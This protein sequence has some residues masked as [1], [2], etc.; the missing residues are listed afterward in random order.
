MLSF[1]LKTILAAGLLSGFVSTSFA[2]W[3]WDRNVTHCNGNYCD[4]QVV[5]KHCDNGKCWVW[6][7]N[8]SWR[9]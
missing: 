2:G 1:K 3:N 4:H 7:E 9:R 8:N 6:R 5:K